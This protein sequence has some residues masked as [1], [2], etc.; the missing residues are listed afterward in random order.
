MNATPAEIGARIKEARKAAKLSQT[1]LAERL[2]KTLRTIQ[3][4]ESGE[5]ELSITSVYT[6]A[7]ALGVS[8][9]YL[10][11]Y[12]KQEIKIETLSDVIYVLKELDKKAGIHFDIDIRRPPHYDE[13][14]CSIKFDGNSEAKNNA[15]LCL[16][17]ERYRYQR[18]RLN[19][20]FT[21]PEF[22]DNWFEDELAYYANCNLP[23]REVEKL[24][25]RERIMRRNEL[26]RKRKIEIQ[27][28]AE[29]NGDQ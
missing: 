1:E 19:D 28:A 3:K 4:Y 20:Y 11:G 15:D 2:G 6:V 9:A 29:E 26:D 8:P 21:S 12:K 23:D 18:N 17:L 22:F 24:T 13:W 10:I 5:I 16:F 27:K 14:T 25:Q 7:G